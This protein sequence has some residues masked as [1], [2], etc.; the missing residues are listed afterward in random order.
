[1]RTKMTLV[2]MMMVMMMV[3]LQMRCELMRT[4]R[5]TDGDATA[6]GCRKRRVK[7]EREK[8]SHRTPPPAA[9]SCIQ[10]PAKVRSS[11]ASTSIVTERTCKGKCIAGTYRDD[12]VLWSQI[13]GLVVS[14]VLRDQSRDI[15]RTGSQGRV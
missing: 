2:M 11:A 8:K 6:G 15:A 7:R 9:A 14:R 5:A 12:H 10:K 4:G 3:K 13:T 1:M